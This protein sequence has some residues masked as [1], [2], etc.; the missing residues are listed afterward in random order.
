MGTF[1]IIVLAAL[2]ITVVIGLIIAYFAVR[3]APHGFEDPEGFHA[4]KKRKE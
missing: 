2:G 1:V 3:K 4:E